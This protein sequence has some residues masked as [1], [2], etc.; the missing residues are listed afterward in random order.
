[1]NQE[2]IGQFIASKRKQK[3]LTQKQLAEKLGITDRAILKW[4]RGLSVPDAEMLI[5]I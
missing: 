1:M 4:E 3:K 2:K 5:T